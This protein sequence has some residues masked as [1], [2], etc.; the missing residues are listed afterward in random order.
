MNLVFRI[1]PK[2]NGKS[3]DL[4]GIWIL[5]D[6][7]PRWKCCRPTNNKS[8]LLNISEVF[9]NTF[10]NSNKIF[11]YVC[12]SEYF[13]IFHS[14]TE[15]ISWNS[16]MIL[17]TVL[18][19]ERLCKPYNYLNFLKTLLTERWFSWI[20]S[21]IWKS[22]FIVYEV[23][24]INVIHH[25]SQMSKYPDDIYFT[26]VLKKPVKLETSRTLTFFSNNKLVHYRK[27]IQN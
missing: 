5:F 2:E 7:R 19:D 11:C 15:P 10:M 17:P 26:F 24:L 20:N 13:S 14:A 6:F 22:Y 9:I 1:T 3:H 16:L 21:T 8:N 27:S 4:G 18:S 12:I 25:F 23:I